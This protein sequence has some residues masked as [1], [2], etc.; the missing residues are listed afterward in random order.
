MMTPIHS[1]TMRLGLKLVSTLLDKV[2]PLVLWCLIEASQQLLQGSL[3]LGKQL[4]EPRV[5]MRQQQR[6]LLPLPPA[7][8]HCCLCQH[9]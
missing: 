3:S 4:H 6:L 9:I 2:Q 8:V 5:A 1:R 7:K